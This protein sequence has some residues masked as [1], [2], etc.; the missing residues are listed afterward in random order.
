MWYLCGYNKNKNYSV[1]KT[2]PG[3]KSIAV[4]EK[5]SWRVIIKKLS[6]MAHTDFYHSPWLQEVL[7][8]FK[9]H[10]CEHALR[11]RFLEAREHDTAL[12]WKD[13]LRDSAKPGN[14]QDPVL[15]VRIEDT[16]L[17]ERIKSAIHDTY[18]KWAAGLTLISCKQVMDRE[19]DRH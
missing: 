13:F 2:P 17:P 3:A 16:P 4:I 6:L 5:S 18:A 19:M 15:G 8:V 10:L 12:T 1:T 7:D 9:S 14:L 11:E